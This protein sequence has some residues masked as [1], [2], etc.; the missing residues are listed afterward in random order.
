MPANA[1]LEEDPEADGDS[2][3]EDI[4]DIMSA[5]AETA[6]GDPDEGANFV[7]GIYK[8]GAEVEKQS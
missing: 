8:L 3:E 1:K 2:E 7:A 5:L 4:S 6:T